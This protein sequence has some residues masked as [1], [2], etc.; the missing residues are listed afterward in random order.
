MPSTTAQD[1]PAVPTASAT[2][3]VPP[4]VL[5]SVAVG[6]DLSGLTPA[7]RLAYYQAVCQSLGLNPLT[8]PF[9]YGVICPTP[10]KGIFQHGSARDGQG[11]NDHR[12]LKMLA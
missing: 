12:R 3:A 6:G 4:E 9:E 11:W 10:Q 7:Q 1:L 2:P 5:E 8:K